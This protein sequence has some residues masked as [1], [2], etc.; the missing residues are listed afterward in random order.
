MFCD[1]HVERLKA[2]QACAF[3]GEFC[4]HG[5][6]Y[7]CRPYAKAEPHLFHKQCFNANGK[8]FEEIDANFPR[9]LVTRFF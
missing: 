3:C 5:L 4:A 1:T 7:M 6:F 9:F 2:H 8:G